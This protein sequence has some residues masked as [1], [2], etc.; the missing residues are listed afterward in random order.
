MH[1]DCDCEHEVNQLEDP[2]LRQ[3]VEAIVRRVVDN[4][5]PETQQRLVPIEVSARHLHIRQE[6]L[7]VLFGPG[8]KLTKLRDLSQP[9]EFAANETVTVVGPKRRLIEKVR[10][11]GPTRKGTQ[12][13]LSYTDGIY[14]GIDLPHRLSGDI[15]G[16]A[17]IVLVGPKGVLDLKEGAIRAMRH[18]HISL[19]Q[20]QRW[21]LRAGQ[22]VNVET[23]G[24][25]R[26]T[27][28]N[29]V[30]R[31][32]ENLRT[33]MHIDTDEAN[34]AGIRTGEIG[35]IVDGSEKDG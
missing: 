2:Q 31:P 32:G 22:K 7:E 34:A 25:M 21:G 29:A 13:E 20:A 16:S 23:Q 1:T 12:V 11:L 5:L 15:K 4:I 8:Y 24:P 19:E 14:L 18:I 17:P 33:C 27:F 6:D 10:I 28:S 35:V 9:G 3:A 30:I 26:V